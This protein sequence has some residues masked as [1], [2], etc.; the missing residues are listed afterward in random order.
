MSWHQLAAAD[1][2]AEE[3]AQARCI[4]DALA[5]AGVDPY[6]PVDRLPERGGWALVR[7]FV[8]GEDE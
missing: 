8:D 3:A 1:L 6:T 7:H 5:D 4:D 2:A